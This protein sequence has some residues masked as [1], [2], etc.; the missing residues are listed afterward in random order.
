MMRMPSE[1]LVNLVNF[2]VGLV[3][4]F[5]GLRIVLKLF[6]ART[7]APFVD[8][9]YDT[10]EPLLSPFAG[11]FPS[12]TIEGGFIV[13]FSALFALMVYA[14][15]GYLL[16]D[17]LDAMTYR[18]ELRGRERERETGRGRGRGNRRDR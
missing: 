3:E 10:T 13:E 9:V 14:F 15:V 2:I 6:G 1:M 7:V 16:V 11:M 8:W 17:V 5:L 12:P 18:N 4:L